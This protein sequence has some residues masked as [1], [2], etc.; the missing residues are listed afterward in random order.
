MTAIAGGRIYP[1]AMF[2]RLLSKIHHLN[3]D[4]R[5]KIVL[6]GPGAWQIAGDPATRKALGIDHVVTGYAEGDA[7]AIFRSLI[8]QEAVPEVVS[9]GWH[10]AV[11]I[12]PIHGASAMGVVEIS[13]GCGLGCSFCTIA[14]VP[15]VHL[16]SEIVLADVRTNVAAGMDN[17]AVLSEDFFRY[18]ADGMKVNPDAPISLLKGIRQIPRVRLIQVDHANMVSAAHYDD[19]QLEILHDLLVGKD[20]RRYVWVNVGVETVSEELLIRAGA[21]GKR[22]REVSRPWG[23][24]CAFHLRR[25]CRAK[26]FPMASLMIGLPGE[27]DEH[28]QETLAW[29]KSLSGERMAV[30][31]LLYAPVD[32]DKPPDPRSLRPLHWELIKACYRLNFRFIPWIYRDNQAAA[33]VS[34]VRRTLLQLMGYGQMLQW[35]ILLARHRRRARR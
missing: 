34:V 26:F 28:L 27:R 6:G 2:R 12:P 15:M 35:K 10:P 22:G 33:G 9:G 1:Q 32:G 7:A 8:R 5:A 16:P 21:A 14:R 19:R 24:F 3:R 18:G 25:L 11:P 4:P 29:V 31:P 23:D 17:V 30:F 20:S 13:R